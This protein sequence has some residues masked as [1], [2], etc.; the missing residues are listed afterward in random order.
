M[1]VTSQVNVVVG[2]GNGA[3][4]IFTYDF[5]IPTGTQV[6]IYTDISGTETTLTSSQ[7]IIT[8]LDNPNGG[9]VIYPTAGSP[10][11]NGTSLTIA[12]ILP[13]EQLVAISN[14]GAFYPAAAEGALDYIMMCLQQIQNETGRA[15]VVPIVDPSQPL[16]LPAVAQR[17][18][19]LLG[20]DT[21]GNPIAAQ[22]S[23]ALVS[24]A[25][26]PVVS[27]ATLAI[28]RM[29]L[30]LGTASAE[31]LLGPIIDDGAGNLTIKAGGITPAMLGSSAFTN[32]SSGTTVDL[33]TVTSHNANI[34][35]STT[36]TSFGSS[37][38]VNSPIY[39][40]TFAGTLTLT[41]DSANLIIPGKRSI[42]TQP[43][44][45]G[46]A[47][48]RGS[49]QW[50][51][52]SYAE[53]SVL[54]TG[55][56]PRGSIN[57]LTMA[58]V[59][60]T[61]FSVAT[62][63]ARNE[64]TGVAV[65]MSLAASLTKTTSSFSAGTSNGGLFNGSIASS[66]WY[67]VYLIQNTSTGAF[68]VGYE[69]NYPPLN[70]PAGYAA[71]RRIGSIATDGSSHFISFS[72]VV[73]RFILTASSTVST[74]AITSTSAQTVTLPV[75]I[76]VNVLADFEAGSTAGSVLTTYI[77]SF[78]QNDETTS[79]D[80]TVAPSYQLAS[81]AGTNRVQAR[82]EIMTNTSAQVRTRNSAATSTVIGLTVYGWT[83]FRG[84]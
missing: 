69:T 11:A 30:G 48:Y 76:G 36:I 81:G 45:Y 68:D 35:G 9:T 19:Q 62:G 13:L 50:S 73:D 60:N 28:A 6:V 41:Y 75:P 14:Q 38:D 77:S 29:L 54:D 43:G 33:G 51:I 3:T 84:K 74:G 4:P 12:R 5:L 58:W 17:A 27:A 82:L 18:N 78:F 15:L 59:S 61:S 1:T 70:V 21:L 72:Q 64:D 44:A 53:Q 46:I 7:Y 49:G 52:L 47:Q 79:T 31:N 42:T 65:N 56:W 2:Q 25:M 20:F 37:A 66:T 71:Y 26:Q 40:I 24:S 23:A 55:A 80:P 39:N 57:G 8:G 32:I 63:T 10:I 16:P 83:D 34:L 22:P 67:H